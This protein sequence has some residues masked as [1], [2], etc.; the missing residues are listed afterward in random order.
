MP[1][2]LK[3]SNPTA[4]AFLLSHW[5][6]IHLAGFA[7]HEYFIHQFFSLSLICTL[8]AFAMWAPLLFQYY[9]SELDKF[10]THYPNIKHNFVNSIFACCTFNFGPI[11]C[12]FNHTDP[13]N[14]PFGWCTITALGKFNPKLGGHLILWDLHLVIEFPPGSTILIPSACLCHGNTAIQEGET[15]YSFTQYTAGGIFRWVNQGFQLTT[16]WRAKLSSHERHREGK[17]G[18]KWWRM[19]V[20]LFSTLNSLQQAPNFDQ[21]F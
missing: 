15:R 11:T 7:S 17:V 2:T 13:G 4:I 10:Y 12:C 18:S 16:E 8:E 21:V 1:R 3:S 9:T 19:S 6:F 14:L 5:A 20:S